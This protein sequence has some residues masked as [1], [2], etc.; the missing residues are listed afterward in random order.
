MESNQGDEIKHQVGNSLTIIGLAYAQ[1]CRK[2]EVLGRNIP[3]MLCE[4][5]RLVR[6]LEKICRDEGIL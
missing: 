3:V 1:Y 2:P 6:K 5:R 4:S